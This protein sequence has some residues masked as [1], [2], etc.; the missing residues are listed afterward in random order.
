MQSPKKRN[1]DQNIKD[2][3]LIF[4]IL[5][6]KIL[7][8]AYN[9]FIFVHTF[10]WTL[11]EFFFNFR[12]SSR[13]SQSQRKLAEKIIHLQCSFAQKPSLTLRTST[14]LTLKIVCSRNKAKNSSHFTNFPANFLCLMSEKAFALHHFL[15]PKNCILEALCK[16][17]SVY[18][19][20]CLNISVYLR[21][22]FSVP[23]T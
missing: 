21:K 11:S 10:Q 2:S 17:M 4:G 18:L 23:E 6:L 13:K 12:F 5:F 20:I 8:W 14:H 19:C 22:K 3:N 15:I 16:E 1:L 7:F 9:S